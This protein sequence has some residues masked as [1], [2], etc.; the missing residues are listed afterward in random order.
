[1][2]QSFP[3]LW[4]QNGLCVGGDAV[5]EGQRSALGLF[6]GSGAVQESGAE[7]A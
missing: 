3:N 1:M 5:G 2:F 6:Q 7:M 4:R